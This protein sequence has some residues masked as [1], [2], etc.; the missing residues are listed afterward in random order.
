MTQSVLTALGFKRKRYDEYLA[1]KQELAKS[2]F[3]VD[4]NLSDD[5]P[6]GQWIK[7]TS[8]HDAEA[9]ELTEKV[10]LS[11][12][13]DTAEGVALDYQVKKYGIYRDQSQAATGYITV[14]LGNGQTIAAGALTVSTTNGIKF[15][16]SLG[17]T[18]TG[19][20]LTLPIV[21]V[22]EGT[23]A[24]VPAN[25]ITVISTPIAGVT[26]VNN[27]EATSGGRLTETDPQLRERYYKTLNRTS[28]STTDGIRAAL[29]EVE[30]IR[31]AVVIENVTDTNDEYGNPPH[32]IAPVVLGGN[33][34]DIGAA[35]LSKKAGG[36][37]SFGTQTI[38][39]K[40][41]SGNDQTIGFSYATK[42]DIYVTVD[43]TKN[44]AFPTN[45]AELAELEVIKYIG[46]AD[47]DNQTYAG[48]GMA[49]SVIHSQIVGAILRNVAGI[50]DL[51]V[52]L[53]KGLSGSF[54]AQNITIGAVEV[55]ETDAAKVTV[56]VS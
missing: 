45:G 26:A 24:N 6:M 40:D 13:I 5:S 2:L 14:T 52:T 41:N 54:L 17:G 25:T 28:S 46:G 42:Q 37:R 32:C 27:A 34:S 18:S 23:Q 44:A 7:L 22:L 12:H 49:T 15:T 51:T 56:N 39:V 1:E 21:A 11:S 20:S 47:I 35:I 33:S 10:W 48:L 43:M 19:T 3:G 38:I 53:R 50:V 55:A 29:L 4:V 36:I 30:D 9:N 8:F 16:N 31:A